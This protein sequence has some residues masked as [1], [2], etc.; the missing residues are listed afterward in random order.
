[1]NVFYR[2]LHS[3]LVTGMQDHR[4]KVG[5]EERVVLQDLAFH[6]LFNRIGPRGT[7]NYSVSAERILANLA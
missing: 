1:M 6:L 3:E 7:N 2:K 5:V 4:R